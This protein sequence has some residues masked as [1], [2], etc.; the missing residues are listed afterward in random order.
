MQTHGSR[1]APAVQVSPA[2]QLPR[3]A[4]KTP[5]HGRSVVTVVED[6]DVVV[7]LD[8]SVVGVEVDVE[9][10]VEVEVDVE[11]EVV[12]V[13][14][15]HDAQ[16]L[17]ASGAPPRTV[18]RSTGFR[19]RQRS[20]W[21]NLMIRQATAPGLPHVDRA[22]QLTIDR[23]QAFGSPC[24]ARSSFTARETHFTWL[25]CGTASSQGHRSVTSCAIAQR[26]AMHSALVG[27]PGRPSGPRPQA[28]RL[29][30]GAV[31]TVTAARAIQTR[32]RGDRPHMAASYACSAAAVA[33]ASIAARARRQSSATSRTCR[34]TTSNAIP[35]PR[36]ASRRAAAS[37]IGAKP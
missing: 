29:T 12:V 4:G 20:V 17:P 30:T 10:E 25:R 19:T 9:V 5:P 1:I 28:G 13:V 26:A 23:L 14:V 3:H 27:V 8:S 24:T 32:V 7:V 35:A 37:E 34:P 36:L 33:S 18:Q 2:G 21:A 31:M 15:G 11:V 22:A 6:V 16:Q